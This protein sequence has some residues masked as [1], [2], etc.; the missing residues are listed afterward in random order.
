MR[1]ITD[2]R[3]VLQKWRL[4]SHNLACEKGKRHFITIK[5]F[6]RE[7]VERAQTHRDPQR[8]PGKHS[9]GAPL[10]KIFLSF[11]N[12]ALW[13][14]L[15]LLS[16][17]EAPKRREARGNLPPTLPFWRACKGKGTEGRGLLP[18]PPSLWH[19]PWRCSVHEI[20]NKVFQRTER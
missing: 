5:I 1:K 7:T 14:T 10:G 18:P 13:C 19:C 17:C 8:S 20:L 9:R 16:D 4:I 2:I 11:I 15:Y 3:V 6:P 12:G